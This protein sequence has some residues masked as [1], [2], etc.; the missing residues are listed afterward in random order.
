[1]LQICDAPGA[2]I[3]NPEI[4]H[5]ALADQFAH[6]AHGLLQR[7]RMILLVQIVDVDEIGAEPLQAFLGGLQHPAP[8]Q[9]AAIGI[10]ADLV[11][12]FCRKDPALPVVG[13]GATDHLFRFPAIIGIR[14]IDEVDSGL[15]RFD[16]DPRRG[17]LVGGAAEHHG[18]EA[19]RR[20]FQAAA[21]ECAVVHGCPHILAVIARSSCD[22]AIQ[23]AATK[24][25]LL[26][27]YAPRNDGD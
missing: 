18:A 26:R 19:D 17:R 12:E 25:G 8:R 13:N 11:G 3:G 5:L 24:S 2:I 16:D 9:P 21:A 1:M 23:N 10:V 15:A 20:D 4:A 6:R 22:E 27:R 7:R 14:S